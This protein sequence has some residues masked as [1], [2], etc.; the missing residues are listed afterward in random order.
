MLEHPGEILDKP[1]SISEVREQPRHGQAA[2]IAQGFV[3]SI[4]ARGVKVSP[5]QKARYL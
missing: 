2:R 4:R 3:I 5:R 1:I